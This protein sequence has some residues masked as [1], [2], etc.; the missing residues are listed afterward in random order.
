[1]KIEI[2]TIISITFII[3]IS[4]YIFNFG[5][6][7]SIVS[8]II[9]GIFPYLIYQEINSRIEKEKEEE[10]IKFSLDLIDLLK[11]GLPLPL[12]LRQIEKN[13]YGRINDLIRNLSSRIDWGI[14]IED[15]FMQFAEESNNNMIKRTIKS[16]IDIYKGGGNLENGLEAIINSIMEVRKIK[17]SRKA[18]MHENIIHSYIVFIFFLGII[19]TFELFLLPFLQISLPGQTSNINVN[20]VT[21]LMYYMSIIQAIF[22]G[23]AM[24]KMYDDSYK[25][26][27]KYILI[28]LFMVIFLFDL[29]L[30]LT[31]KGSFFINILG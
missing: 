5:L 21:N 22:A 9:F 14:N 26:G 6:L 29:V 17:E 2:I 24:G 8:G 11:S 20:F 7:D 12:A 30:P 28:F 13:D 15:S 4:F 10:F 1:M 3:L 19:F 23:L 27:A 25:A 16:L 18:E 31:P